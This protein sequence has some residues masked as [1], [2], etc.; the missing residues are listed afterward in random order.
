MAPRT[1]KQKENIKRYRE[2]N[3]DIILERNRTRYRSD[4]G[5]YVYAMLKRAENRAKRKGIS[6]E[7]TASDIVIPKV[8]PILGTELV[9]GAGQGPSDAS[10]SLDRISLDRGYVPGNVE[11]ISMKANRIKSDVS[12]ED[13]EKVLEYLKHRTTK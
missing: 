4:S 1:E 5:R 10:P 13:I 11:V 6:F 2:K 12:I 3:R 7:L 9:I 8:C